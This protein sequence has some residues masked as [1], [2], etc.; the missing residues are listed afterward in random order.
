MNC[1]IT[2]FDGF[3]IKG[4]ATK[5]CGSTNGKNGAW[6]QKSKIPRCVDVTPPNIIC[7]DDYDIELNGN[8]SFVLLKDFKPMKLVE[9]KCY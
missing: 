6:T 7:P 3:D 2:C 1:T 5:S 4:P 9:G 8:K